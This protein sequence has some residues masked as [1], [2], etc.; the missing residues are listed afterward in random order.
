MFKIQLIYPKL[1]INVYLIFLNK[2]DLTFGI[3]L[4]VTKNSLAGPSFLL[5][6]FCYPAV[7]VFV[8]LR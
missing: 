3:T 4:V 7:S 6:K 5:R 2:G 1:K 8:I